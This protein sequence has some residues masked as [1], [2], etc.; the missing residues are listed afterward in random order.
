MESCVCPDIGLLGFNLIIFMGIALFIS[1]SANINMVS[2]YAGLNSLNSLTF[3]QTS[4]K[5]L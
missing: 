4:E 5:E 3:N 1:V 2:N